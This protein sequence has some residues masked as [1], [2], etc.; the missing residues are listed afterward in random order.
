MRPR[1][2][3]AYPAEP[4]QV[5]SNAPGSRAFDYAHGIGSWVTME[6]GAS[7]TRTPSDTNSPWPNFSHGL[8]DTPDYSP[9]SPHAPASSSTWPG[10]PLETLSR[11][12]ANARLSSPWK[13]HPAV[14]RSMSYNGDQSGQFP[15][16]S[17]RPYDRAQLSMAPQ[18]KI[19][20]VPGMAL[21]AHNGSLSAGA[22]P[23]STYGAWHQPYQYTKANGDYGGWYGEP[24]E[25]QP[26]AHVSSASEDPS[27]AGGMYYG[28]R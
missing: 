10:A 11:I 12:D 16:P 2:D 1:G 28:G 21:N 13:L 17:T 26:E 3:E 6:A 9:Y 23:H 22:E 24:G 19:E 4:K 27:Q 18:V 14:T 8:P 15:P 20:P 25:H 5:P 7:A